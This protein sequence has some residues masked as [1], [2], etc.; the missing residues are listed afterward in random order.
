MTCEDKLHIRVEYIAFK[1]LFFQKKWAI[2][3]W[4]TRIQI[5]AESFFCIFYFNLDLDAATYWV[6]MLQKY[7]FAF[8]IKNCT[9]TLQKL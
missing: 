4:K 6:R 3:N 5:G 8:L 1:V 7:D 9:R 2:V